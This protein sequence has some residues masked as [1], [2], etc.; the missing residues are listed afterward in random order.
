[1]SPIG[2]SEG[3]LLTD[4]GESPDS[5]MAQSPTHTTVYVVPLSLAEDREEA[6][7]IP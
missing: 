4:V 3:L 5:D 2:N 6:G 7:Q 1:M